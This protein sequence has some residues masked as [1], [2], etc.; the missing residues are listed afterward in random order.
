MIKEP[1]M[2]AMVKLDMR[3][4]QDKQYQA[5]VSGLVVMEVASVEAWKNK[6]L[7]NITFATHKF[8]DIFNEAQNERHYVPDSDTAMQA[9]TFTQIGK[10][11]FDTMKMSLRAMDNGTKYW[12]VGCVPRF[13]VL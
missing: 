7:G 9:L 3:D 2:Y 4:I 11:A 5:P 10:E 12:C 6:V 1:T 13:L 8:V